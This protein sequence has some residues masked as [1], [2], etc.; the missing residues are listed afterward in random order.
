MKKAII[1]FS[2]FLAAF[3]AKADVITNYVYVV[4]NIFNN[5]YSESIITQKVKST[6]TD[7]YFTNY[8]SIVT[9]VY[10]NQT[11]YQTN[12][13]VNVIFDNFEPWVIAASNY[14]ANASSFAD[15]AA[16]SATTAGASASTAAMHANT[17][18]SAA[19]AAQDAESDGIRRI[20]ER[21]AWFDEHSGETIT[22]NVT[23]INVSVTTNMNVS[24]RTLSVDYTSESQSTYNVIYTNAVSGTVWPKITVHPW[25]IDG[26]ATVAAYANETYAGV[27]ILA[28]PYCR[29]G[30][31]IWKFQPAYIDSDDKG[32]RLQYVPEEMIEIPYADNQGAY[33][34][35][36][37]VPEYLYWQDGYL[38]MKVNVWTNHAVAGWCKSRLVYNTYPRPI[39]YEPNPTLSTSGL[40]ITLESRYRYGNN[41][42]TPTYGGWFLHTS[43]NSGR[44]EFPQLLSPSL[45]STVD[46][47]KHGPWP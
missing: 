31:L 9:N 19:H 39:N 11:T 45:M 28:W 14:A 44:F 10:L 12:I 29:S 21:I 35:G 34:G 38:N 6:H 18:W 16:Q 22:M 42:P 15:D 36:K 26:G 33:A 32:M 4:S 27:A 47:M 46:W 7:Y 5:V 37:I 30:S 20:N 40:G 24:R 8:V 3:T 1:A 17:A 41:S 25:G 43:R 2:I 13:E 23:N